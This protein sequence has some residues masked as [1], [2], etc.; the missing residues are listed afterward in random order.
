MKSELG[1]NYEDVVLAMFKKPDEYDASQLRKAMKVRYRS[2]CLY[3]IPG[4]TKLVLLT[5]SSLEFQINGQ[6]MES[7]AFSQN[8]PSFLGRGKSILTR[9]S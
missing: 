5:V 6:R 9:I 7:C 4:M 8:A 2:D 1:G 3:E